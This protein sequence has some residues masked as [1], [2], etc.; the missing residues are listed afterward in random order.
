MLG[1]STVGA[2]LRVPYIVCDGGP[3]SAGSG[4]G[5]KHAGIW[6]L[7]HVPSFALSATSCDTDDT[8]STNAFS[9]LFA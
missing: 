8:F 1:L 4:S 3:D 5:K 2:E 9:F 6:F 7:F